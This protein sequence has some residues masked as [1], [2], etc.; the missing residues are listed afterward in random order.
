MKAW[1]QG[2]VL[3]AVGLVNQVRGQEPPVLQPMP[4]EMIQI[5]PDIQPAQASKSPPQEQVAPRMIPLPEGTQPCDFTDRHGQRRQRVRTLIHNRGYGC[6]TDPTFPGCTNLRE[7]F[8]F[9]FGSCRSFF[10]EPCLPKNP[11]PRV[12][13]RPYGDH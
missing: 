12:V 10:G 4:M 5:I 11:P 8:R 6:G 7:E 3:V 1:I 2:M 13:N 9:I